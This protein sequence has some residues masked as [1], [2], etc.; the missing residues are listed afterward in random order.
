MTL[1]AT[2]AEVKREMKSERTIADNQVLAGIRQV[3]RRIDRMFYKRPA[4]FFAPYIETRANYRLTASRVNSVDG[5]FIFDE[6]LLSLTGVVIGT[7]TLVVG[8]DVQAFAS[9]YAPYD[10][11]Q[12]TD[13]CCNGW[14]RYASCSGC[15]G[16]QYVSISGT[17]G[18]NV[19]WSHAWL[20]TLQTI[21]NVGGIDSDDTSFTVT[22]VDAA[23][24]NGITPA[25]SAG[26]MIQIDTEWMEV[27][28]TDTATNTATVKRAVNG[29]TAAVHAQGTA[30]YAYQLEEGVK[31]ATVRQVALQYAK[32]GG[33]PN[34]DVPDLANVE[35]PPD[36]VGE[37]YEVLSLYAN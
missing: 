16:L 10:T 25:L 29:S 9:E 19:D 5:T 36:V 22:D 7:N 24:A 18:Y 15:F 2:L 31:R 6:P 33:Y 11:L 26:N 1:Y 3:S 20:N 30:I 4:P 28:A 14:F 12:L 17:W 21:T 23:N 35:L 34:Q 32:I 37:F 13:R 8:T 27:T